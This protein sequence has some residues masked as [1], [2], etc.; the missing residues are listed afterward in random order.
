MPDSSLDSPAA[1]GE[2]LPAVPDTGAPAVAAPPTPEGRHALD[3]AQAFARQATA[4][5]TLRAYKAD[6]QHF[7]QWCAR[8]GF[9]PVPA[10]PAVVGA[11]LASLAESHAPT[12]IPGALP[13]SARCI[14]S[15]A[16]RGPRRT[17][18]SRSRCAACCA[19]TDRPRKR[20]HP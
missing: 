2:L 5:A 17:V 3:R 20:R 16:S 12:T 10:E 9:V 11:Y 13:P 4:P 1:A 19:S 14:A 7:S 15:T 8:S 6:W 18:T